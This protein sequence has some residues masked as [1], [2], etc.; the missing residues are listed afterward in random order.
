MLRGRTA[1]SYCNRPNTSRVAR[2]ARLKLGHAVVRYAFQNFT[3][4]RAVRPATTYCGSDTV[5]QIGFTLRG[6]PRLDG[7]QPHGGLA[8]N[9]KTI[10]DVTLANSNGSLRPYALW[11]QTNS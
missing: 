7:F 8:V 9:L 5:E 3:A 4:I 6:S 1:D 11:R 10:L 2:V